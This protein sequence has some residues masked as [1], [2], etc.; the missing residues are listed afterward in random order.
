MFT[1]ALSTL[2]ARKGA[3][4]GAFVA[5]FCAAVLVTACAALL[6]TGLRGRIPT[7]RY[8]G[9]PLLVTADQ[10]V[11]WTE[12]KKGKTKEKAKPLTE[13]AWL[14]AATVERLATL[15]G[16]RAAL[17]E[18]TFP[19]HLVA[20]DGRVAGGA[21]WGH[22]WESAALTPFELRA[23]RA[24]AATDEVVL[25]AALGVA[26]GGTVTV[27]S[28]AAPTAYRVVG[29]AAPADGPALKRQSTLFFS[30]AEA[31]RL[32]GHPGQVAAIGLLTAPGANPTAV[33]RTALDALSGSTLQVRTG[34]GR[35][36]A[37]FLDAGKARVSL[38]TLGAAM[39]G[40]SL[41]VALLV[42]TGT[43]AL[44]IQQRARELA[45]L[46]AVGATPR[47][48]RRMV[49]R[50]AQVVG[51]LAGVPGA[52]A[53]LALARWMHGRFVEVGA[54]P[55]TL[56][57]TLS[58]FP[59]CLAVLATLL[60][61]W[62]A[63]RVSARR[64]ARV[65]PTEGLAEA[66]MPKPGIGPVRLIAGLLVAAGY[67]VLVF[68]LTGLR[69]EAAATPV[70][71]LSVILAA[72]AIALL[73]PL[74]T[75]VATAVLGRVG[76][77]V[78]PATGFLAAQNTRAN[79]QRLAAVVTPLSLAV[80]MASTILFT[81]TT[82]SHA[83]RE[84]AVQGTLAPYVLAAAGPG[85]PEAAA[86]AVRQVP[87]VTAVTEVL[88]TT[89]RA[90]QDK[91]PAQGVSSPGLARTL[92]PKVTAG[93]LDALA[94]DTVAVSELAAL[95]KGV[96]VGDRLPVTL[97]D[98]TTVQLRVVAVYQRGLGHGDLTLPHRLVA[99]HV[100]NPLASSVLIAGTADATALRA[101]VRAFPAVRVLDRDQVDAA[102][103]AKAGTQA[104]VN[105]VAMGLIIA[106]TGIA[107]VNTLVM[108]TAARRRE[109]AMLRLIGTTGRQIRAMLRWETLT[110]ALLAVAL[111]TAVAYLTLGAYSSGM[112]GSATPY[113]PPL[114]YLAV[115][116]VATAL[117]FTAT[118]LPARL[119]LRANAADAIGARE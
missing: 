33:R 69:T 31:R 59:P 2:R 46:R 92:D 117:A 11:H 23:G 51:L 81:Q 76:Q 99:A 118:A 48:L 6:E 78:S 18:L 91:F 100:D 8:A 9:T 74:V 13:R 114:T 70:T 106:F 72:A 49:G 95:T 16:V 15:P 67:A 57:L 105:Y 21:S 26:V 101:A 110:V 30:T 84:Q 39:G 77:L 87:G 41:L 63:A 36:E 112:T 98:G 103:Q 83:A 3:F 108:A 82:A 86:A 43:F 111:G 37:E 93:S 85:V 10:E 38:V 115:V 52:F 62:G 54:L 25:D 89:V 90:G 17:P 97:G 68:V 29:L 116:G 109:F 58:A 55:D 7:E 20:P 45:L 60:A 65:H 28:T 34:E 47:Q 12:E 50:E 42:V 71:F 35:G 24:P 88:R 102:Q 66:A 27:Q 79:A 19:A 1:L 40:T 14:D 96:E 73:G 22:S 5:L 56:E 64:P 44:S 94:D 32:A 113:A 104:Q 53:G 61:A 75:R 4:V 119:A 80:A 107:V